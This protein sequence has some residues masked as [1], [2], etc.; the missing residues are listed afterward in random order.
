MQQLWMKYSKEKATKGKSKPI[1]LE[2]SVKYLEIKILTNSY[3]EL[4]QQ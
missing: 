3:K 2:S 1:S 4:L